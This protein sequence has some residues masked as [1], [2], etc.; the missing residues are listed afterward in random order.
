MLNKIVDFFILSCGCGMQ[1]LVGLT[2]TWSWVSIA[3]NFEDVYHIQYI[4]VFS[5]LLSDIVDGP[6]FLKN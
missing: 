2:P 3:P 5:M 6:T 4:L 1:W